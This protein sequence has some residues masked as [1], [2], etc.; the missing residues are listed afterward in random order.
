M[1]KIAL[2]ILV[3]LLCSCNKELTTNNSDQQVQISA[4]I[5]SA[6]LS[7]VTEDGKAFP[8]GNAIKVQNR[9]PSALS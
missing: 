5:P 6:T 9:V 1:K 7:R 3:I 2:T 8:D 4:E